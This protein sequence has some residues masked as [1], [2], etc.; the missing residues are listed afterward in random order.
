VVVFG[1][2]LTAPAWLKTEA[3]PY[4]P[5][6]PRFVFPAWF[7]VPAWLKTS[8]VPPGVMEP[9]GEVEEAECAPDPTTAKQ[10]TMTAAATAMTSISVRGAGPGEAPGAD[11][12]VPIRTA[13]V[14]APYYPYQLVFREGAVSRSAEW[15]GRDYDHNGFGPSE[16]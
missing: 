11:I 1:P 10:P 5:F 12:E 4:D 13:R 6:T 8:R 3:G 15:T 14:P 2:E 16:K 7:T 9:L